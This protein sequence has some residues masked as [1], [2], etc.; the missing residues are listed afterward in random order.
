MNIKK[1]GL[2]A[3]YQG[4][5]IEVLRQLPER[6]VH[7]CITS[8]PYWGLRDYGIPPS[9]WGGDPACLHAWGDDINRSTKTRN[10]AIGKA[11]TADGREG[12]GGNFCRLCDAWR[13]NLGLEPTPTLFIEHIGTVF[14]EVRRV[15]RDDGTLWLNMGDGYAARRSYQVS[16]NKNPAVGPTRFMGRAV[17]PN[18]L[19]QKDLIMMPARVALALQADGWYLRSMIPWLKRNA[20]PESV[21]DRPATATEYVFLL[22]KSERYFYDGEAVKIK[23]SDGT[24]ARRSY[25]TPDGWDTTSGEGGHGS[26]HKKGRENGKY[27]GTGVGF[28][29]GTDKEE[30]ARGRVLGV[31]PKSQPT[32]SEVRGNESFH[33]A[34]VGHVATRNRRNSDSFFESWQGLLTD[35]EGEPLALIV[36]PQPFKEAHFATFPPKLVEPMILAGTSERG[37]CAEC[38]APWKRDLDVKYENPGNRTTNGPRSAERAHE[39]AGYDVRLERRATTTGWQPSCKCGITET[40][41]ATILDPFGGAGTTALVADRLQRN[42]IIIEIKQGYIDLAEQRLTQDAPLFA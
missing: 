34:T 16:D 12:P 39:T 7:C 22:A 25:K 17:P 42:A 14:R 23:S 29:H 24:H 35:D 15:L 32:G 21:T 2:A 11:S 10:G 40:V 26:I 20:M 19:K 37:C 28:G 4:D 31:G 9:V 8:P 41:P 13:G 3:I 33:S 6:S 5:C 18:G 30:R 36:N 27:P 1:I 38:G